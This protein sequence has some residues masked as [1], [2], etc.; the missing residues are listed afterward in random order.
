VERWAIAPIRKRQFF[1]LG[2]VQQAVREQL[3]ILNHKIMQGVGRIRRQE[4]EVLDLPNL[5]PLPERPY[6]YAERKT[7]KV[8]I[9]YHVEFDD[10]LYSVPFTLVHQTVDIQATEKMVEI[11]HLGEIVAIH[12]RNYRRGRY[13]TLRDHMPPNHRFMKEIDVDRLIE[14]ADHIGPHTSALV[15]ATL[16]SR[17]YPEQAYRTCLGI[18]GLAR[19]HSRDDLET[20]CQVAYEARVFS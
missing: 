8:H 3:E 6:E 4:F 16:R 7:A 17:T 1:S 15:Q 18:L 20:A 19:K 9:D 2:E 11:F 5:K 10:H 13:S 12:P 14:W